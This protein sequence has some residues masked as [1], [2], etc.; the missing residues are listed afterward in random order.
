M[1]SRAYLRA[2]RLYCYDSTRDRAAN[3]VYALFLENRAGQKDLVRLR[4]RDGDRGYGLLDLEAESADADADADTDTD[5]RPVPP[6]L[7]VNVRKAALIAGPVLP[8]RA[9]GAGGGA[10]DGPTT[11]EASSVHHPATEFSPVPFLNY[12]YALWEPGAKRFFTAANGVAF[13]PYKTL[14]RIYCY[15]ANMGYEDT[16]PFNELDNWGSSVSS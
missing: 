8:E 4:L 2:E 12:C 13:F 15:K 6:G 1:L 9:T 5:A 10:A 16:I 7:R 11:R 3:D 14:A